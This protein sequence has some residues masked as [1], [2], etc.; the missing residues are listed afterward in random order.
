MKSFLLT[1]DLEDTGD[2]FSKMG[3]KLSENIIRKIEEDGLKKIIDF[4]DD[5]KIK[6]TFF[7]TLSFF[8]DHKDLIK[9]LIRKSHEIGLHAYSHDHRYDV[10]PE[11]DSKRFLEKAK[12]KIEKELKIKVYGFRAPEM[13]PPSYKILKDLGFKYDSSR[14]PTPVTF[15]YNGLF[16]QFFKSRKVVEEKITVVPVSVT[17]IIKLPFSWIWFRNMGNPYN[18]ICT[19]LSLINN[20][21]INIYFHNWD[22]IDLSKFDYKKSRI[23]NLIVRNSGDKGLSILK[24]YLLWAKKQGFVFKTIKKFLGDKN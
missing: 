21:F 7:I 12:R 18:K 11:T 3:I 14:H 8:K 16:K 20:G 6:A 13:R 1:F 10:M 22:F 2:L 9:K 23:N 24:E 17:P 15:L 5:L 4:L 19:R